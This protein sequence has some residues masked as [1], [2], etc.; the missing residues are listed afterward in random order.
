MEQ[1][2]AILVLYEVGLL[3]VVSSIV[4]EFFKRIKLPGLIGAIVVGLFIGGPGGLG[5]VTDFTVINTLAVLG[6]ILILFTVGLDFETSTFWKAGSHAFLLTTCGMVSSLLSGYLIGLA[7]GWSSLAAFLLGVVIAPSGTSVIAALLSSEG[8][9]ETKGG[10]TLLTA[11]IVDDVEGVLL[12]T[13][14]LSLL[15]KERLLLADFFWIGMV[16]TLFILASIYFGGKLFPKLVYT[17]EKIFSDEILFIILL[18]LGMIFAYVATYFGLAAITGAFIMG[19]IIPKRKIGEKIVHRLFPMKEIFASIFFTSIGLSIN[20]FYIPH[21]LPMAILV[22]GVAITA[23][24]VGGA[25][26]GFIAGFRRKTLFALI[27]GLA[28]RAEMSLII[29]RE[30]VAVGIVG[31][32]FLALTATLVIGSMIITLPLLLKLSERLS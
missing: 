28:V 26:G 23:R 20:P 24:L 3:I 8:K 5:L 18:G 19:A 10:S 22:L 4:A 11:C 32:E 7:L 13:I 15:T 12:L 30:G 29:A 16:S 1:S 21:L 25:L 17:F 6:S 14:A 31:D 9:V 2:H 27:I